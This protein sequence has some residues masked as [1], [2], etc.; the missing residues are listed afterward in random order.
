M[1]PT[2]YLLHPSR[3]QTAELTIYQGNIYEGF[4]DFV[5]LDSFETFKMLKINNKLNPHTSSDSIILNVQYTNE[6]CQFGFWLFKIV[7]Y[8]FDSKVSKLWKNALDLRLII[9]ILF[10]Y[11]YHSDSDSF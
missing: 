1:R 11:M 8:Q 6:K 10:L 4:K 9:E 2:L 3:P 7:S 5:S